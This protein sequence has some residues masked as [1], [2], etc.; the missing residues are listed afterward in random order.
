M[1]KLNRYLDE[2]F[3][4]PEKKE[5]EKEFYYEFEETNYFDTANPRQYVDI[6]TSYNVYL[7]FIPYRSKYKHIWKIHN[8]SNGN[9]LSKEYYKKHKVKISVKKKIHYQKNKTK[10]K[11]SNLNYYYKTRREFAM[12]KITCECG[13]TV[14]NSSYLTHLKS[15]IHKR[16]L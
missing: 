5:E 2:L 12:K 10:I 3:P 11:N 8:R 14:S 15:N 6:S 16:N 4:K 7:T 13:R 1:E 9:I